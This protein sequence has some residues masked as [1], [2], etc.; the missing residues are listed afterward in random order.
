VIHPSISRRPDPALGTLATSADVTAVRYAWRA[1][2][3]VGAGGSCLAY[4]PL[5]SEQSSSRPSGPPSPQEEA[6]L[7]PSLFRPDSGF[8]RDRWVRDHDGNP[9]W[10]GSNGHT[11]PGR[12][13]TFWPQHGAAYSTSLDELAECSR[14]AADWLDGFLTGAEPDG[15]LIEGGGFDY[16]ERDPR[17]AWYVENWR[18]FHLTGNWVCDKDEDMSGREVAWP[19]IW[20]DSP[21]SPTR[22]D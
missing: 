5:M 8:R 10:L 17:T 21:T 18:Q 1:L 15:R 6:S 16:D 20:E 3:A 4:P 12:F 11:F 13:L 2:G 9:G 22:L 7:P 19:T 14:A